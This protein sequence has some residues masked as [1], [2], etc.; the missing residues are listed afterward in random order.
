MA[1]SFAS[2]LSLLKDILLPILLLPRSKPDDAKQ[3]RINID[4]VSNVIKKN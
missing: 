3:R 4:S 2:D 1:G